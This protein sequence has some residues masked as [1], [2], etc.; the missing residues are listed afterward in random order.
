MGFP[1]PWSFLLLVVSLLFLL[2][3]TRAFPWVLSPWLGAAFSDST[4]V[5]PAKGLRGLRWGIPI[6]GPGSRQSSPLVALA[7]SRPWA[8]TRWEVP[9]PSAGGEA[10]GESSRVSFF[11]LLRLIWWEGK[12]RPEPAKGLLEDSVNHRTRRGLQSWRIWWGYFLHV[13]LKQFLLQ[14]TLF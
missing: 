1:S 13:T 10:G 4:S 14:Q 5:K 11:C 12:C 9:L 7:W 2:F 6:S 3:S 8:C